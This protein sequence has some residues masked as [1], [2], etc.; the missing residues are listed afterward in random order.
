MKLISQSALLILAAAILLLALTG[1]LFSGSPLV[2]AGQVLALLLAVWA[3]RSF[4]A[5]QFSIQAAPAG[6]GVISSGPYQF[7]RHPMYAAALLLIW[8]SIAGHFS[9]LTLGIGV[10]VTAVILIRIA[11]EETLLQAS[12]PDYLAYAGRTKR[13]IP[14]LF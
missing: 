1:N 12:Y 8:A 4:A 7:I 9:P 14:F 6:G 10:G 11:A 2:I 5:A 3:R 13:I